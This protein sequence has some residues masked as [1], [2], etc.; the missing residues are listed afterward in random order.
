MKY[1]LG[2]QPLTTPQSGRADGLEHIVLGN[3][4][5]S[6]SGP[7]LGKMLLPKNDASPKRSSLTSTSDKKIISPDYKTIN[8]QTNFEKQLTNYFRVDNSTNN[9]DDTRPGELNQNIDQDQN[10]KPD[11]EYVNAFTNDLSDISQAGFYDPSNTNFDQRPG[12]AFYTEPY[13]NHYEKQTDTTQ[14]GFISFSGAPYDKRDYVQHG[15]VPLNKVTALLGNKQGGTRPGSD[16]KA[17]TRNAEFSRMRY[18]SPRKFG[19][20]YF[21]DQKLEDEEKEKERQK[22]ERQKAIEEKQK[23]LFYPKPSP[24]K[25]K[26]GTVIQTFEK[27]KAQQA[28][29]VKVEQD[30]KG[31]PKK[32]FSEFDF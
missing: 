26:N 10:N 22:I 27:P 6:I 13:L 16:M 8:T 23:E 32:L 15:A 3:L 14:R 24:W 12:S 25:M 30:Q 18:P 5:K 9:P 17:D 11:S 20:N 29:K 2:M 28:I 19:W 31:R 21:K 7:S 4:D 1:T